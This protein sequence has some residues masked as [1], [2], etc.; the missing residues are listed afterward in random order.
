MKVE[1]QFSLL[2]YAFVKK[3]QKKTL[4]WKYWLKKHEVLDFWK[5]PSVMF[6]DYHKKQFK[7]IFFFFLQGTFFLTALKQ[8]I[9]DEISQSN[10]IKSQ[11]I[12]SFMIFWWF[13][14]HK[15]NFCWKVPSKVIYNFYLKHQKYP[16]CAT[17]FHPL[18]ETE[19][20]GNWVDGVSWII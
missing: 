15:G 18:S 16:F 5:V 13:I 2:N 11:N 4:K 7:V 1:K 9:S 3:K 19:S 10:G 8:M 20:Y 14:P 17:I 6:L 12:S